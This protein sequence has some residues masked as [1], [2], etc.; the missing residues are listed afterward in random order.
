M[1]LNKKI[2]FGSIVGILNLGPIVPAIL[3]WSVP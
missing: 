3:N 2:I 1:N